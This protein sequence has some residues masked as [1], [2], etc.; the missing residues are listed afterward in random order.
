MTD[1]TYNGWTNYETWNCKL[2]I[3]SEQSTHEYW[4]EQARFQTTA[5]GYQAYKGR[6]GGVFDERPDRLAVNALASQLEESFEADAELHYG[7]MAGFLV[8]M[9][10]AA[11][12]RVN[13]V[14]IAENLIESVTEEGQS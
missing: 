7:A 2:W 3:D 8:D 13:W 5:E 9:V 4:L 10:N 11:L 12:G 1:T 14:E 6:F